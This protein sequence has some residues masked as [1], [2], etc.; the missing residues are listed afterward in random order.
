VSALEF[1]YRDG[2]IYFPR[3]RLWFDPHRAKDE[4]AF[5]SHAH[6]DHTARHR[7]VILTGPTARLMQA[8]LGGKRVEHILAFGEPRMF[9]HDGIGFQLTLLP[10]GHILGSAMALIECDGESLLYTGDFKLRPGLAAEVCEPR[11]ANVLIMETTFGQPRYKFPDSVEVMRD[12]VCFCRET[13][14][15]NATALLQCY[16]L[17]KTQEVLCG[18]A[19]AGLPIALHESAFA[20]T[21][22][23]EHFGH[24]FPAYEQ[25]ADGHGRGWVVVCPPGASRPASV[26]LGPSR[27]AVIT[28]WALDSGCKYQNRCDVA[29][30]LSD[31]ADFPDLIEF[32]QR[33]QPR[34]VHTLHGFAADFA[35]T[36]RRLGFDSSALS[37]DEQLE[38]QL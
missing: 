23:Y 21:K 25:L 26:Q 31:H 17:G 15:S 32:V 30:P 20:M 9:Q 2:G 3:L 38:L 27:S 6:S 24:Q 1:H 19:R 10:A 29:F 13:I 16:S 22:I 8:R 28:G 33:V 5:V 11:R 36:L 18:L 12:V 37:E 4:L 14:E 35:G 7:E 34:R